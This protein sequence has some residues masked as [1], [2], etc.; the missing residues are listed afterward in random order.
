MAVKHKE[1]RLKVFENRILRPKSDANGEWRRF[2]NEGLHSLYRVPNIVRVNKS[3]RLS[4]KKLGV[5]L[6]ILTGKPT[7]KR[8]LRR[9]RCRWED[10]IRSQYVL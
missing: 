2:Y 3:T 1:F 7:G 6:N 8:P 9:P 10:N 4:W 5:L